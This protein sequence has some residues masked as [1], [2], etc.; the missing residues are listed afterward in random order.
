[1]QVFKR[2]FFTMNA[3]FQNG[4]HFLLRKAVI[5]PQYLFQ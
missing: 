2:F 4:I 5:F 1:M 3:L